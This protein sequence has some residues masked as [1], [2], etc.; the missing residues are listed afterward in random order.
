MTNVSTRSPCQPQ[1]NSRYVIPASRNHITMTSEASSLVGDFW[2]ILQPLA[3][4]WKT[5][6]GS[7]WKPRKDEYR[8][9]F[10][11]EGT[12]KQRHEGEQADENQDVVVFNSGSIWQ[13]DDKFGDANEG[14]DDYDEHDDHRCDA[15][16][17]H[18]FDDDDDDDDDEDGGGGGGGGGVAGG[19]GWGW[20]WWWRRPGC[21][22]GG[23]SGWIRSRDWSISSWMAP[24]RIA[25]VFLEN[26]REHHRKPIQSN[27]KVFSFQLAS[28]KLPC[29]KIPDFC[30]FVPP[31]AIEPIPTPPRSQE[32]HRYRWRLGRSHR[33][34]LR[35]FLA[36]CCQLRGHLLLG[37][38]GDLSLHSGR[39]RDLYIYI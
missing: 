16:C 24:L 35:W 30:F 9:Y 39:E 13:W 1:S 17:D 26:F 38:E 29:W 23:H 34:S 7:S 10:Y 18:Y 25:A 3:I 4:C 12:H 32:H 20:W 6:K 36:R 14:G 19:G 33:T 37:E 11:W 28:F 15:D 2:V 5:A 22:G 31:S 27:R 8:F 21:G